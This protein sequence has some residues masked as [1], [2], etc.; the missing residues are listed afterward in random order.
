MYFKQKEDTNIDNQLK[1]D[2]K[3]NISK[4][5]IITIIIVLA[6]VAIAILL[7][8]LV[9][10]LNRYTLILKGD[11]EIT[12]YQGSI[13]VEP[14]YDAYDNR[15]KSLNDEVNI[16]SNLDP[17]TIGTYTI[18]Y[19][20]HD[21][22]KTR[23]IKVVEQPPVIT[24]IYLNGDKN[25]Y[26]S[27]GSDYVEPGYNAIDAI[28]GDLTNKVNVN[29]NVDTSKKGTYQIIYSVVNSAG[30]TTTETRTIIVQ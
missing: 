14:G 12:I 7:P 29:S 22:V 19:T 25:I 4:K 17:N 9:M 6:V 1:S 30:V 10:I 2:K 24:V 26:M 23:N 11:S 8:M 3:I 15:K 28:D 21:K 27:Q 16:Q 5:T 20:L 13:Y 18:T